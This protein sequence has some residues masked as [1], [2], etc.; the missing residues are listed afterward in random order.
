MY[1]AQPSFFEWCVYT[2]CTL[3]VSISCQKVKWHW[4][5]RK[6]QV[7][8]L[9]SSG[10]EKVITLHPEVAENIPLGSKVTLPTA[11]ILSGKNARAFL[12]CGFLMKSFKKNILKI[13]KKSWEP[14]GSYLLNNTD[15]PAHVSRKIA[16][17]I[18]WPLVDS[19]NFQQYYQTNIFK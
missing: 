13:W 3:S 11:E 1:F 12:V 4:K 9:I 17:E 14:F 5:L 2:F 16:F 19:I 6:C 15:N 10:N 18:Y 8:K 7:L